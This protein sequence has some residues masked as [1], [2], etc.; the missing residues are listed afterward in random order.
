MVTTSR[1]TGEGF[2]ERDKIGVKFSVVG[3]R[4]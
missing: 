4:R 3:I 2:H 1:V